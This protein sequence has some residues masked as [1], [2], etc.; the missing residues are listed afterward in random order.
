MSGRGW[1]VVTG[2]QAEG[3]IFIHL[4]DDSGFTAVRV[5]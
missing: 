4:G 3:Q 2:D 5:G 1:M